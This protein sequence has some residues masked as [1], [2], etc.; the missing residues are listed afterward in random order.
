MPIDAI[1]KAIKEAKEKCADEKIDES[2][3]KST[4]R[5]LKAVIKDT[6]LKAHI[7]LKN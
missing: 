4:A 6:A 3:M 1:K 5:I 2:N 7:N